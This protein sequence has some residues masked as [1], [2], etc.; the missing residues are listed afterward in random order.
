MTDVEERGLFIDGRFGP[1]D[2]GGTFPVFNPHTDEV[3]S[4]VAQ[5]GEAD[6]EAAIDAARAAFEGPWGALTPKDRGKFLLKLARIIQAEGES[7]ARLEAKNTGH[8]IHDVRRFDLVRTVDWFEYF[9]GMATKIQGDVIPS[10]FKGV[11]NYTLREPLGVVGQIVPWNF[12]LMFVAWN[13]AAALAAGDAVV[14]K[15]AEYTPMSALEVA[16]LSVDAG[17]PPGTINVVPGKGSVAGARLA[18]HPDVAKICFTGSV[19]VGQ[20]I[21]RAGADTLKKPL[22]ELGGKGPN[23][24]FADAD[25]AA[26]VQGSLFS[27][28]H[29]QGQACIAGSRL[30]V[31][32]S[33]WDDFLKRFTA[34]VRSIRLGNPLEEATQLRPLTTKDHQK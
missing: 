23:I 18:R 17:F 28:Y 21:I 6:A 24:V 15:P 29:N 19:E 11:L 10:S 25:L 16:R 31:H 27:A 3:F 22:L 14:L 13:I 26:A 9:A 32:E 12:P 7:L 34:R 30:F 1:S 4:K 20:D 33:I 5:A 8:P 2:S